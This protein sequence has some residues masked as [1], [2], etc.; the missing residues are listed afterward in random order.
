MNSRKTKF[1]SKVVFLP[2][3]NGKS[4][5][6][7]GVGGPHYVKRKEE[8]QIMKRC[9]QLICLVLISKK[10]YAEYQFTS[11]VSLEIKTKAPIIV[12]FEMQ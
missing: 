2:V 10:P 11:T 4:A 12:I 8:R 9:K 1:S 7:S 6:S 5:V 3:E